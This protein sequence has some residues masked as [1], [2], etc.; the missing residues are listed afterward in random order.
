MLLTLVFSTL[1]IVTGFAINEL[2]LK[3]YLALGMLIVTILV[4]YMIIVF[5]V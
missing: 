2:N 3:A 1:F 4:I 5:Y